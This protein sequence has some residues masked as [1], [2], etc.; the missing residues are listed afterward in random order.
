MKNLEQK[1]QQQVPRRVPASWREQILTQARESAGAAAGKASDRGEEHLGVGEPSW[2]TLLIGWVKAWVSP[3]PAALV[4]LMALW[5]ATLGFNLAL[6]EEKPVSTFAQ[7]SPS[8]PVPAVVQLSLLQQERLRRELLD[9]TPEV[10]GALAPPLKPPAG[11]PRRS[12]VVSPYH[13][14]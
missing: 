7:A 10:S 1:L 11:L 2:I 14:A 4:T 12:A 5:V 8:A 9:L 3:S 6:P 13:Y